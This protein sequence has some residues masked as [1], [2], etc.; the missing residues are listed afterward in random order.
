MLKILSVFTPELL[1]LRTASILGKTNCNN[2]EQILYAQIEI[3]IMLM[4]KHDNAKPVMYKKRYSQ[5]TF[6]K[7][8]FLGS[9]LGV[10]QET[11]L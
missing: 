4:L 11:I 1:Y 6:M 10:N 9:N 3:I 8:L 2:S 5:Q 7:K